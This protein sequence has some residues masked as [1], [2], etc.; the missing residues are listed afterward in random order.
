MDGRKPDSALEQRVEVSDSQNVSLSSGNMC[1]RQNRCFMVIAS[2]CSTITR[3][4]FPL[5]SPLAHVLG[6]LPAERLEASSLWGCRAAGRG[7]TRPAERGPAAPPPLQATL[8]VPA[9]D[10][11]SAAVPAAWRRRLALIVTVFMPQG[12]LWKP[13]VAA[14][15]RVP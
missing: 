9:P 4:G 5:L 2:L 1:A 13:I 6:P 14:G 11:D 8:S 7:V 10:A 12:R 15:A 3:C